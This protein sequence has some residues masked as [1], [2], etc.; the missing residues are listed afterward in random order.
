LSLATRFRC[1]SHFSRIVLSHNVV[2]PRL[3]RDEGDGDEK[4]A[5]DESLHA[6]AVVVSVVVVVV[7]VDVDA[8]PALCPSL[9]V[10]VRTAPCSARLPE[11][12][13]ALLRAARAAAE[14]RRRRAQRLRLRTLRCGHGVRPPCG[15]KYTMSI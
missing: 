6:V 9:K 1:T 2:T 4:N 12:S 15:R 11:T 5:Q 14:E 3:T 10:G 7:V 8:L 13:A